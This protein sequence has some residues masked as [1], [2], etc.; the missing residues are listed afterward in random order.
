MEHSRAIVHV[1]LDAFFASVEQLDDPSCA[2][3]PLLVG[4]VGPRSV[5]SAASYEA[6]A[7]G[8]R[9]AMPMRHA[10]RLCPH[11]IVRAPRLRRYGELSRCFMEVL[12]E[13]SPSVEPL[14]LD[15]AF[16]DLTGTERL[17][18]PATETI[19]AIVT[20]VHKV[21]GLHCSIGL[22]Q[23]KFVAK[24]ASDLRKPRGEVVV[25]E[26]S[27][28]G[29]LAPLE[30]ARMWGVGPVA[31][32]RFRRCGYQRF[33][34]LQNASESRVRLDLGESGVTAW[35]LARGIDLREV[36]CDSSRKSIGQEET[37]DQDVSDLEQLRVVLLA[38][39]EAVGIRLRD[40]GLRAR[41]ITLKVRTGD[42]RTVT[43]RTTRAS[44]TNGGSELWKDAQRVFAA[45]ASGGAAP[46]RLIGVSVSAL[47]TAG[48]SCELFEDP[49]VERQRRLE[50]AADRVR[51]RFGASALHRAAIEVRSTE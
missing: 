2:G 6:R 38:Q 15:E 11:A 26:E 16:V 8:C 31:E 44:A 29:F 1:D 20:R 36:R 42:F 49:V 22:A 34:D 27:V 41:T 5:V 13:F 17:L 14:S 18:G 39:V 35:Q 40:Q 3:R 46:L 45:W 33:A 23:S 37:F 12:R 30:I 50:G 32:E 48:E 9:A 28:L 7:F 25:H 24:I 51:W 19:K 4:G 43:R 47:E 21:T 10:Q